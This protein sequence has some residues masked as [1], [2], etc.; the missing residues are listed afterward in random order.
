MRFEYQFEWDP[1]KARQNLKEHRFSFERAATVF[2]D[3]HGLSISDSEHSQVEERW[4][5]MGLDRTG[6]VL[7]VCHTFRDETESS[8]LVRMI[9]ARKANRS[10]IRQY[11][12]EQP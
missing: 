8:V 4:I 5:T 7:V 12:E 1:I 9:S 10:E 3:S 11:S 6:V 2:L